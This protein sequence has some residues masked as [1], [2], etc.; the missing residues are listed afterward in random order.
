MYD[1]KTVEP[2]RGDDPLPGGRKEPW[3]P[4]PE[5]NPAFFRGRNKFPP[6]STGGKDIR[7]AKFGVSLAANYLGGQRPGCT[8]IPTLT[9]RIR[10][11]P[12]RTP[13]FRFR[14]PVFAGQENA[15]KFY[16]LSGKLLLSSSGLC[17]VVA[18]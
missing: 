5:N 1:R 17:T 13:S 6:Q 18:G 2:V 16:V 15:R 14:C 11:T 7:P 8:D 3:R 9:L 10:V 4:V 12:P